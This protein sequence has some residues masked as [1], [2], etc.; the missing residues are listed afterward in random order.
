[1]KAR[2]PNTNACGVV[3]FAVIPC[4]EFSEYKKHWEQ[5]KLQKSFLEH[6]DN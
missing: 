6:L 3:S 1:M 4:T 5:D 2:E